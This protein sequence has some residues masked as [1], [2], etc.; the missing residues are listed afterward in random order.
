MRLPRSV[1]GLPGTSEIVFLLARESA[2]HA[3]KNFISEGVLNTAD[4]AALVELRWRH[5]FFNSDVT[6]IR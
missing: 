3:S 2:W 5:F 1:T 6:N 4:L